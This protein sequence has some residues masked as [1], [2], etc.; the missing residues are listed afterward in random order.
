MIFRFSLYGFLKNQRY[1]EPFLYLVLLEYGLSF[2]QIGLLVGFRE[3]SVSLFELPSGALADTLG[4]RKLMT[5]S[6][7]AYIA[8][9]AVFAIST[10]M[11]ALYGAMLLLA[12]GD[13]SRSGTHKAMIFAWLCHEGRQSEK[14]EVYGYT[15]SWSKLGSALSV[16][17]AAI[18]VCVAD[19]YAHIFWYSIP[20]YLLGL[21]NF[22]GYPSYLDGERTGKERPKLWPHF[23]DSLR[24]CWRQR[25]LRWLCLES[26]SF[27]GSY[28]A[29]KDYL[30][31]VLAAT[32]LAFLSTSAF[33]A[34]QRTAIA[35][36]VVYMILHLLSSWASRRAHRLSEW[37][38]GEEPAAAFIWWLSAGILAIL[39]A[40]CWW[41]LHSL[42]IVVFIALA[43]LQNVWRPLLMARFDAHTTSA[44][45][46]TILSVESQCK[47]GGAFLLAPVFGYCADHQGFW[48]LG[49]IAGVLALLTVV[50]SQHSR[51]SR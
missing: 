49:V 42:I 48:T 9:F 16:V 44:N 34:T 51:R 39:A 5:V 43:M 25:P 33:S 24:S 3:I 21:T 46:A 17:L 6:F 28:K 12:W 29:L 2:L 30:Q 50:L 19:S 40:A 13:A 10:A 22:A 26:M 31:P 38:G 4:R 36:G 45:S 18:F 41:E 37:R 14:V 8:A 47:S 7:L 32:A 20:P 11:P 15:R 27:E 1:F 35:V 23:R